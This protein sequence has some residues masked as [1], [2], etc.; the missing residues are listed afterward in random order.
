MKSPRPLI[1]G[2]LAATALLLGSG[3]AVQASFAA[4]SPTVSPL[5][6]LV[7]KIAAKFNLNK[8]EVQAVF[9]E[10]KAVH[11]A[12]MNAELKELAEEQLSRAVTDG[13]LTQAQKDLITAKQTETQ[14]KTEEALTIEDEGDRQAALDQIHADLSKWAAKNDID[15]RWLR[16]GVSDMKRLHMRGGPFRDHMLGGPDHFPDSSAKASATA[17]N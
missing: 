17:A 5:N 10:E 7:E 8:E 2:S 3:L 16:F 9:D 13:E 1:L 15:V 12:E 6:G 4:D 11:L 14:Q